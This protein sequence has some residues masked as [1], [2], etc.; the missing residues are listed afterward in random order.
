MDHS[1]LIDA[2]GGTGAVA[3]AIGCHPGRVTRY[4]SAGIPPARFPAVVAL[5]RRV[6][7]RGVTYQTLFDALP[8]NRT[9]EPAA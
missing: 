1:T 5:A 9:P 4:R 2:L 3:R 7:V 6:G 8:T